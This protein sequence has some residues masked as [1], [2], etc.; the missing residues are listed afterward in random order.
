MA[1]D[2][3]NWISDDVGSH[4]FAHDI[5]DWLRKCGNMDL[6]KFALAGDKEVLDWLP[7]WVARGLLNMKRKMR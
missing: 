7:H 5:E 3:T 4:R 1:S 6:F 2:L